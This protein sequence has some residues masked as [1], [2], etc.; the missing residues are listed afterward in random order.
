[1]KT[2][3]RSGLITLAFSL[4][5]LCVFAACAL[6][7]VIM[8]ARVYRSTAAEMTADY[9][10]RTC[11]GYVSEKVRQNGEPGAVAAGSFGDGDALE[12]SQSIDG[13]K[14][15]T[16]IYTYGVKLREIFARADAQLDPA[17]GQ[18]IMDIASFSVSANGGLYTVSFTDTGGET[19]SVSL[20]PRCG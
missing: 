1:M 2:E 20:Y 5:L 14:Y 6:L 18:A 19:A 17:T 8:G 12:L 11:A 7:V 9:N 16:Y 13:E 3:S 4:S 10:V 15:T